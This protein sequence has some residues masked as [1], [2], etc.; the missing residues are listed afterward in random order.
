MLRSVDQE[1]ELL[2]HHLQGMLDQGMTEREISIARSSYMLGRCTK[3]IEIT[4]N[5]KLFKGKD[6][7]ET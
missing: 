4:K 6:E 1:I 5:R 7:D 2:A 3:E